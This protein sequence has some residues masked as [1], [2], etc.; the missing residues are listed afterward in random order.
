MIQAI[1][2]TGVLSQEKARA[3][4]ETAAAALK[5]PG[6]VL[7]IVP[8]G[9]RTAPMGFIFKTLYRVLEP[10]TDKLDFLI[11]LGTH[12]PMTEAAINQRFELSGAERKKRYKKARFFN[13]RWD[14]PAQLKTIGILPSD[15]VSKISGGLMRD[16][17]EV[18]INRMIFNYLSANANLK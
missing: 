7:F 16:A 15:E 9:S 14:D 2:E 6:R 5:V 12:P 8:D 11:A 4:I 3:F 17:V 18:T 10:K 13:H 1:A